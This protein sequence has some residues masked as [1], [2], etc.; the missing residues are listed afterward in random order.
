[1][2]K[3]TGQLFVG[4]QDDCV[5]GRP[6]WSVVHACKVPCHRRA[7]EYRSRLPRDHP[8]FLAHERGNDLFLN[9]IDPVRPRF[10]PEVFHRFL[11]FAS[12]RL[13]TGDALLIHCNLGRSRA[14]S[15]ALLLMARRLGLLP[16]D[17]YDAARSAFL[18]VFPYY[19]PRRGVET[20]LRQHWPSF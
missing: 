1:M 17:S 19:R 16:D 7:L 20:F 13:A 18:A 8:G 10:Q 15:L 3:V 14:P 2:Q 12:R 6:G 5:P 4:S 9:L 11:D